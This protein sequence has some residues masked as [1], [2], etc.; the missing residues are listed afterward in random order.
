MPKK[1]KK[2][3][4]KEKNKAIKKNKA[5]LFL[6]GFFYNFKKSL[7]SFLIIL[8]IGLQIALLLTYIYFI[9]KD[10][11]FATESIRDTLTYQGKITNADGVPPPD[12]LYN[13]QFKI[14]DQL[15]GGTLLWTETWDSSNQGVAGSKVQVTEGIFTVELN[16]LC[17]NWVGSCASNG[18]ITFATDSFYLQVELDY[19]ANGSFEEIFTPRKRFTATPYSM[20]AD[21]LDGQDSTDFVAVEGDTMTGAL[22]TPKIT[23][24]SIIA[25]YQFNN[26]AKDSSANGLDGTLQN[27]APVSN[28]IL[29]LDGTNQ[30]V[31]VADDDLL[32]FGGTVDHDFSVSSWVRATDA[33]NFTILGKGIYNTS[34]EY[35]FFIDAND[36]INFQI[37]DE[38]VDSCYLGRLYDTALT[39]SQGE[40]IYLVATY[41][42]SVGNSAGIKI[43][44][45]GNQV[46]DTNS[47]NSAGSYVAMENLAADLFIGRYDVNYAK[48]ALDEVKITNRVLSADEVKHLYESEKRSQLHANKVTTHTLY[49]AYVDNNESESGYLTW[50]AIFNRIKISTEVYSPNS[51]P[52][53]AN[54]ANQQ[55]YTHFTD[56]N[57]ILAYD[58]YQSVGS[59]VKDL[60]ENADGTVNGDADWTN[61][62][63]IGYGMKFGTDGDSVSFSSPVGLSSTQGSI[64]F[65]V[66]F[67]D[68]TATDNY[69][70]RMSESASNEIVFAKDTAHNIYFKVGNSDKISLGALPDTNWHHIVITW[71]SGTYEFFADGQSALSSSYSG[72]DVSLFDKFYLGSAGSA[73]TSLD[74]SLDSVAIYNDVL[75]EAEIKN[76]YNSAFENLYIANN[77]SDGNISASL[78]SLAGL[79][80]SNN[81]NDK[82]DPVYFTNDSKVVGLAFSEG[83]GTTTANVTDA[84]NPTI[85][86]TKWT[87]GYYGYGLNFNGVSDYLSITDSANINMGTDNFSLEFYIKADTGDQTNKRIISKRSGDAGYEVYFDSN[88]KIIFFIGDGVNTFVG[89]VTGG[90]ALNDGKWHNVM[91]AFDRASNVTIAYDSS[92]VYAQNITAVTGSLDNAADLY[93]G[94]DSS[95]N[96]Y[97][98]ILDSVILYKGMILNL[99]DIV[100][101]KTNSPDILFLNSRG[102]VSGAAT[103]LVLNNYPGGDGSIT[104]LLDSNNSA[105]YPLKIWNQ[106]SYVSG[107]DTVY[108]L[109]YFGQM[110]VNYGNLI[111]DDTNTQFI[112]DQ[113]VKTTGDLIANYLKTGDNE[114][115][116]FDVIRYTVTGEEGTEFT[117]PWIKATKDKIVSM[118]GVHYVTG[119]NVYADQD[120]WSYNM[121][122]RI[123]YDGIDIRVDKLGGTWTVN[124]V[125]TIF[126]VYEK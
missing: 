108:N 91:I 20:N 121:E 64:E 48:G 100:A 96:F 66:K 109:I 79:S 10:K 24:N 74:G 73:N 87:K 54:Q 118:H 84:D 34:A 125:I 83:Q 101:R 41:D 45:N 97:K 47:E 53:I 30:Y 1:N 11:L 19:D 80:A 12:G 62:G 119:G 2:E 106:A 71:N 14:Y 75:T 95:G 4:V 25:L 31:S 69:A 16:S 27:S 61:L 59:T 15:S 92:L 104:G 21:K 90:A 23:D 81:E 86:G 72:L 44:L 112:F 107:S 8:L 85:T 98:G 17:G 46:D 88:N 122:N 9:Y 3:L 38:S 110:G 126:I 93:I 22:S 18:G 105:G 39:S 114:F 63:Y 68:T 7:K 49:L 116:A 111:W 94:K 32:S 123:E 6:S 51:M 82:S 42:F 77:L 43:Y 13:M 103:L 5:N 28:D 120:F 99:A 29:E 60:A 36:K 40:W 37:Y 52:Q 50:D 57:K 33:T 117:V 56:S 26:D 115:L 67:N 55:D 78:G 58:F 89:N 76:H 65:W 102:G 35:R 70:I 124:D 113:S